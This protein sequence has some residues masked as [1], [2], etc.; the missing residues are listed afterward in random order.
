METPAK[1]EK[2]YVPYL[3][4]LRVMATIAVVMI[5]VS[6]QNWGNV[7]VMS[8]E[9]IIFNIYNRAAQWAVPMFLMISGALM[10]D[11]SRPMP[12]KKLYRVNILRILAAFFFWSALY[13]LDAYWVDQDWRG[14]VVLFIGGNYHMWFLFMILGFYLLTPAYR[15]IVESAEILAYFLIVMFTVTLLLPSVSSFLQ[16]INLP[17]T[18]TV[19]PPLITD[20]SLTR[21]GFLPAYTFYYFLGSYLAQWDVGKRGRRISYLLGIAAYFFT[22]LVSFYHEAKTGEDSVPLDFGTMEAMMCMALFLFAKYDLPAA[23]SGHYKGVKALSVCS[24]GVY[25]SHVFVITKLRDWANINTLTFLPVL[26]IPILVITV[27][28]IAFLISWTLHQI[29]VLKKYVV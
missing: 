18:A 17:H 2:A 4:Y 26:S 1:A 6:A 29:P 19:L 20:L 9:W 7:P 12:V 3:D 23:H 21:M 8:S 13:A 22:L 24:F 10:L 25:L 5:H 11:P 14:A 27:F 16:Y 28:L 15:K